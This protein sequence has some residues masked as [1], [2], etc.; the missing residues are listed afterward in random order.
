MRLWAFCT[1]FLCMFPWQPVSGEEETAT[2]LQPVTPSVQV[3]TSGFHATELPLNLPNLNNLRY[4][5]DGA[6]YAL[7]YN[8]NLW[9]LR[10]SNGDGLEDEAE[11][12][13]ENKT[14]L[15]GPIGMAVIP[16][17]HALFRRGEQQV[18]SA[19]GV[20]VP[21]KGKLSA[22]IDWDGDN[23]ADEERVIAAGWTEIA[24]AVDAIGAVISPQDGSIYFGLGTAD[25]ENA[26]QVDKEG[27]GHFDL[28]SERGTIQRISPDLSTREN[29]CTGVRFTIGLAFNGD[30]E[31]FATDQEG[32]TWMPNGNPFDELLHVRK[33]RHYGFPPRHPRHL[34]RVFDEPSLFDYAPQHQSTCGL[35]FN[36]PLEK[37]GPIFGPEEFRGDA[38]VTG[39]S[40]GKIYRTTLVRTPDG[41]YLAKNVIFAQL[42]ML[43]VDCTL[44]PD[45]GMLVCC[46][47]GGP[48]WGTGPSGEGKIFKFTY[49]P[50]ES[51]RPVAAWAS[52]PQET[53]IAFEGPLDLSL[54]QGLVKN[55][56][57]TAGPFVSAGDR[58]ETL[59]PGYEVVQRQSN[60]PPQSVQVYSASIGQDGR[61]L[62][63]A[64]SP[65]TEAV[66]Y[67]VQLPSLGR[68]ASTPVAEEIPQ[69]AQQDVDYTLA[70]VLAAWEPETAQAGLQPAEPVGAGLQSLAW[71]N[72]L[73]H[74]DPE[75]DRQL[76]KGVLQHSAK[77]ESL[78][79]K[80]KYSWSTCV[81]TQG[82]FLPVTQP[83]ATLDYSP[84]DENWLVGRKLLIRCSLPFRAALRGGKL[85]PSSEQ[86]DAS[87][88]KHSLALDLGANDE[89]LIP[90]QFECETGSGPLR[91]GVDYLAEFEDGSSQRGVLPFGRLLTPWAVRASGKK[92]GPVKRVISELAGANWGRGRQVFRGAEAACV[93]CHRAHGE[94]GEIG[95]DLSNLVHR[96]YASV[97]RDIAHPSF[98]INPDYISYIVQ[99]HSGQLLTGPLRNQDGKLLIADAQGKVTQLDRR[100]IEQMKPSPLSIMPDDLV[101]K[102]GEEKFKDLLAFLLLPGPSVPLE[103]PEPAPPLRTRKELADLLQGSEKT[104]N[105]QAKELN[106]LLVAGPQDH[107]PGEHDY[108]AWLACWSQLLYAAD[109]VRVDTAMNWPSSE[110]IA[111]ADVIV[112]YQRGEWTV[113]RS[114]AID[115]HLGQGKGL[116]YIHWAVEGG[117]QAPAFARRI[118]LA[119]DSSKTKYR[120]GP[121]QLDWS[122]GAAHPIARNLK[123][124]SLVDESYWNLLG[125]VRQASTLAVGGP[126]A[127]TS[128]PPLFWTMEPRGGRV[129]VSI[130]GHY[131]WTFNDP[132]YRTI[133]LRGIAWAAQQPVDRFNEIVP[134]GVEFAP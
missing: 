48:D 122:G 101:Q 23:H 109:N 1:P 33:G 7:G 2:P 44:C 132:I 18:D 98:A 131:S 25:F 13:F 123:R 129:F 119:S 71:Q 99:T 56:F 127:D 8:G 20:I 22:M 69:A 115:R 81:N 134:L 10:D 49:R 91:L 21:S 103:S 79:Q 93:R 12:F 117:D 52:G 89:E 73:A 55:V 50:V 67:A 60:A 133:L 19:Q 130:P 51:P 6:L 3:L 107:G 54:L 80:G 61:T 124:L 17:G 57:I 59:R 126:E 4:R 116:V 108:P 82:L 95:P 9:L 78:V 100:D 47:S 105:A 74:P 94:G 53:Q 84:Q 87:G 76:R 128:A 120:H 45:G 112:F 121:L 88:R 62:V 86:A 29:V 28:K 64:T 83:G 42:S 114:A 37:D 46:H 70:G 66:R 30:N 39:E 40:R 16:R 90:L 34:P 97:R 118:G 27:K 104:G 106:L 75:I 32:A 24:P 72:M 5:P 68:D 113:E 63:L 36:N 92:N 85:L 41:E 26:H 14:E 31:L 43:A 125:D 65:Q 15:R 58:F 110:Q 11:L 102:L 38:F 111:A 35:F 96:D 77:L